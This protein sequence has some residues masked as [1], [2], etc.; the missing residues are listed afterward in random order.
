M[1]AEVNRMADGFYTGFWY[2][3]NPSCVNNR[4]Y[5]SFTVA[6]LRASLSLAR[7]GAVSPKILLSHAPVHGQLRFRIGTNSWIRKRLIGGE[8]KVPRAVMLSASILQRDGRKR[9]FLFPHPLVCVF[10]T[11]ADLCIRICVN[12]VTVEYF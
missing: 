6:I 3:A 2:R 8:L 1:P 12:N 10:R 4:R 11:R 9:S 5:P 7:T